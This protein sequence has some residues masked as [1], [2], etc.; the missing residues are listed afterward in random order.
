[1][2]PSISNPPAISGLDL[3][4]AEF[5]TADDWAS[6]YEGIWGTLGKQTQAQFDQHL[7]NVNSVYDDTDGRF[8]WTLHFW[9][10][11]LVAMAGI[12][13]QK[14]Y[15]DTCV[16]F[17]D[18]MFD[19]TD[20]RRAEGGETITYTRDPLLFRGTG[21]GGPFWKRG[22]QADAYITGQIT[23]SIMV[24][25]DFVYG[26]KWA[27]PF[28]CKADEY[29]AQVKTAIDAFDN[30]WQWFGN[31]GSYFYR[32]SAGSGN[33]GITKTAFNQSA[34]MLRAQLYV[35]RWEPNDARAEKIRRHVNYWLE[36]F[37]TLNPDGTLVYPYI[38]NDVTVE[39]ANHAVLDL[40]FLI[41]AY[42]SKLTNLSADHMNRFAKTFV[43]KVYDGSN[44]VNK[45]ID[46][47]PDAGFDG[48]FEA[49]ISWLD[50][51]LFDPS[52]AGIVLGIFNAHYLADGSGSTLWARPMLGW[53]NI[54]KAA[55]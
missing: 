45:F 20:Q 7:L 39:D 55:Q 35:H 40:D 36:E 14:K 16:S 29:F 41:A 19:H 50:L 9:I 17:I 21:L 31:K 37:V 4:A 32:D 2:T 38:T 12:T 43:T 46:G 15:L 30:D 47:T 42:H 3:S 44:G 25:V 49:G 1:M 52:I 24:F 27:R 33:L 8:A 6:V 54:L 13:E 34:T 11:A 28:R 51:A 23:N 48:N 26:N 5:K 10:K 18:Y 53:A 22:S